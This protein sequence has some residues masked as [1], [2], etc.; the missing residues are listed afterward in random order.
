M[1][2]KAAELGI[3]RVEQIV[4]ARGL[5]VAEIAVDILHNGLILELSHPPENGF[6]KI[7]ESDL[8]PR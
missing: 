5:S 2:S 1:T 8:K 6:S 3:G 4:E 7:G